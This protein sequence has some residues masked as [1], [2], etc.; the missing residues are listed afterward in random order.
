MANEM[1]TFTE[2]EMV[3]LYHYID[4]VAIVTTF[5]MLHYISETAEAEEAPGK[6]EA[7]EK[8]FREELGR[9]KNNASK[10][11]SKTVFKIFM[12]SLL[13]AFDELNESNESEE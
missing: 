6:I 9:V 8:D 5:D 1:F 4:S 13:R 10:K 2:D 12:V 3:E 11:V 7:L